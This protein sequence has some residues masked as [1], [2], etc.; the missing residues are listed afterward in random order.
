MK[1]PVFLLL[2]AA[3]CL[4][5]FCGCDAAIDSANAPASADSIREITLTGSGAESSAAGVRISGST[6]TLTAAG[7]YSVTG[8]LKNGQILVDTGEDAGK[9]S[10]ILR[11][12]RIENPDGAAL[13]VKQ[14]KKL[15]LVIAD[16]SD[17]VL[18]SGTQD[19]V[20][21][22]NASGGAIYA[23]DDLDIE[24]DG[25]GSLHVYGY[26][27]SGIVCKDDLEI[28][29]GESSLGV[30]AVNNGIKG[31]ESVTVSGGAVEVFA[32]HDGI[33]SSSAEKAG[34]GFV[35]ISGGVVEL[36][37]NG[38][39]IAAE[40]FLDISGG[41]VN[42]TTEGDPNEA[43]CKALKGKT[44]VSIS[45]GA[46]ELC[47]ADH[48][49]HSAEGITLSGGSAEITAESA[50]CFA[51]HGDID[52]SGGAFR[53]DSG[54][55]AVETK[56][57]IHITGGSLLVCAASD[58]FRADGEMTVNGGEIL[59][60]SDGKHPKYFS[61]DS[62][63]PCAY[64]DMTGGSGTAVS[65]AGMEITATRPF[66]FVT[67]SAPALTADNVTITAGA[68]SVSGTPRATGA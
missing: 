12:A 49:V 18:L 60:L 54:D 40:S 64:S 48:A 39:G 9:V 41:V 46:L 14:A 42:I 47:S 67:V 6:V 43:S 61:A 24:A 34:K 19:G 50:K 30:F 17:N 66:R 68:K 13:W 37:A 15:D 16:G 3:L 21:D 31:S 63:Q 65:A 10:L 52:I 32:G 5:L 29:C 59:A 8:E 58:A 2:L 53:L 56:G 44:G 20:R 55:D 1:K 11:N 62:T 33:K 27:N 28:K 38:D 7:T 23:E 22:P 51:A 57:S 35:R 26:I 25:K 36:H 4:G 45:G